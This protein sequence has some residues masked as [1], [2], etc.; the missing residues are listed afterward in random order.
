[1]HPAHSSEGLELQSIPLRGDKG[2]RKQTAFPMLRALLQGIGCEQKPRCIAGSVS[3]VS[4]SSRL[5]T[6]WILQH[7]RFLRAG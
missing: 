4:G 1:M 6:G 7:L 2:K 3:L 5:G